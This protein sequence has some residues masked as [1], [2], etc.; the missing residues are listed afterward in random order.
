MMKITSVCIAFILFCTQVPGQTKL[1]IEK[2]LETA[3]AKSF[4]IRSADL[5]LQIS[6]NNL[7]AIQRGYRTSVDVEFDAPRFSRSL[8]SQFNPLI[9]SEQFYEL[10]NTTYEGRIYF[11]Q[12]LVFSNGTFSLTGSVFTRDQQT[13]SN[14]SITD[15][16]TN[17]SL[18][19]R[20][21]LF[22]FNTL[23]ANL[24]RASL[25]LQ[26]A[27]KNFLRASEDLRYQVTAGFFQ[28]YQ[29]MQEVAIAKEKLAQTE[30]SFTTATNKFKAGIIAEVDVLQVEIDYSTAK[31]D[32][33]NAG[34]KYNEQL[35]NLKLLLGLEGDEEIVP[36]ADLTYTPIHIDTTS[37]FETALNNR[38]EVFNARAD[39]ELNEV[40]ADETAAKGRITA[41]LTANYGI[42]KNDTLL[43]DLFRKFAQDRSVTLTVSIPV[44]DWG[45]NNLETQAKLADLKLAGITLDNAKRQVVKEVKTLLQK[46]NSAR[47]RAEALE[48]TVELAE[49]SYSI[50]KERYQAGTMTT[51]D[52]MQAQIKLTNSKLNRLSALIDYKLALAELR[53]RTY[54]QIPF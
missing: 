15:Y 5:Q 8:K 4:T 7:E 11:T 18:R 26:K 17:L 53:R 44:W 22:G 41:M 32:L 39:V 34:F 6:K 36:E 30:L 2:A 40:S 50:S 9:G 23:N 38:A 24:K 14:P 42:N 45:K 49:K 19:L 25:N 48:K 52:L 47:N 33:L 37:I 21:P 10:G 35:D 46:V 20:Q 27:E 28:T 51:F 3:F 29:A 43:S 12:P 13:A 31:N 54:L 1:T 16:F